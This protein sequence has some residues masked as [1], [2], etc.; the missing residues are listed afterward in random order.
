MSEGGETFPR[1]YKL[2]SRD[3]GNDILHILYPGVLVYIGDRILNMT[4]RDSM[5]PTAHLILHF[6]LT[7]IPE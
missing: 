4:H 3:V 5:L 7:Y 6:I 2:I 1:V